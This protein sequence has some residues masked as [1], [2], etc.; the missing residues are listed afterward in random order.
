VEEGAGGVAVEKPQNVRRNGRVGCPQPTETRT[1]APPG[2]ALRY[3]D[4][5][6]HPVTPI[7]PHPDTLSAPLN[8]RHQGDEVGGLQ[9]G[10]P[11]R[12]AIPH[13]DQQVAVPAP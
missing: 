4:P 7:L 10:I 1:A 3:P 8:R 13:R 9:P 2:A 5:C 11:G 12:V 6:F